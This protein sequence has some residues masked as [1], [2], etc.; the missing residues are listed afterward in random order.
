MT[1]QP[2]T[3]DRP[4]EEFAR[5]M[6]GH[7]TSA[8]IAMMASVGHRTG[9]FDVMAA[10]PPSQSDEIASAASLNERYVREWL[11]AMTTA[12]IVDY[13]PATRRFSLPPEHAASLT[14]AAGV[15]NMATF[16]QLLSAVG[17]VEDELVRSFREGGGV[18]HSS[19]RG[20]DEAMSELGDPW[21]EQTVA[22]IKELSPTLV[23]RL[24]AGAD[25]LEIG[26]G[27]G[28]AAIMLAKRFPRSRFLGIDISLGA[29][30]IARK[31]ARAE[32]V[33]NVRFEVADASALDEADRYGAIFSFNAIHDQAKP[34]VVLKKIHRALRP[35]GVFMM[36][37]LAGAT[38]L[39]HNLDSPFATLFYTLSCFYTLTVSLSQG[40]LGL[41]AMW[42]EE[43][44]VKLLTSL[45]FADIRVRT[46]D[47]DPGSTYFL[48]HKKLL[49]FNG[50]ETWTS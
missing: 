39:H 31:R 5:T 45:G 27:R 14:R 47:D 19:Y 17:S 44:I 36:Q 12:G 8:A 24:D 43:M 46:L 9:L 33:E 23:Q 25:A 21:R 13:H 18:P 42:G 3:T 20:F 40:G 2:L 38:E 28:Y 30:D 10:M 37:E 49:S 50:E 11:S 15:S 26:C 29:I 32:G 22:S 4:A 6:M 35:S 7:V 41:G 48:C 34:D 1:V 16:A